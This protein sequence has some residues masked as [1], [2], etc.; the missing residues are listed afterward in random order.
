[1]LSYLNSEKPPESENFVSI[2]PYEESAKLLEV[3]IMALVTSLAEL[4]YPPP[5]AES[6]GGDDFAISGLSRESPANPGM[7]P[8]YGN[9]ECAYTPPRSQHDTV[10]EKI[11]GP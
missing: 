4:V 9:P 1:M 7:I 3:S 5:A 10:P 6:A 11:I 2:W 8:F